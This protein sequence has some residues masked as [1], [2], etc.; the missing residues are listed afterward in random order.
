MARNFGFG[1]RT[2][3]NLPGEVPGVLKRTRNWSRFSPVAF[4]YGHEIAVTSLQMAMAYGVIANNGI[5]M[6]PAIVQE[7]RNKTKG[8][9]YR[10]EPKQIRKVL[11]PEVALELTK[12]LVDVVESGTGENA[13]IAGHLIA[14]KTG[15]A[16]KPNEDGR[17][18][19]YKD[20]IASFAGFY[21]AYDPK[22]LIYVNI[23]NPWPVHSGGSVAA[24]TFKRILQRILEV[25]DERFFKSTAITQKSMSTDSNSAVPAVTGR[26]TTTASRLLSVA[27]IR[28]SIVGD[29]VIVTG[30]KNSA[31]E[32]GASTVLLMTADYPVRDT[33]QKMPKLVGLPLRTAIAELT[34]RGIIAKVYGTGEVTKQSP[35]PGILIKQG[36]RSLL[37][38]RP[39]THIE[40]LGKL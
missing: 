5:L 31:G 36:A 13:K 24:P 38:C 21:P 19:S 28:H 11:E 23:D 2:G 7:I 10:F 27:G 6:K 14:G 26:A 34:A 3:I 18:Y 16:Q 20:F 35:E 9:V 22:I 4:S 17:G 1:N 33:G 25:Y 30:Q 39:R 37:E 12:M 40:S 8:S 15:T 29:G 32:D